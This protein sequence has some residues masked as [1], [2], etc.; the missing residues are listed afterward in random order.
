MGS[1]LELSIPFQL[2]VTLNAYQQTD[3]ILDNTTFPE[4]NLQGKWELL[5]GSEFSFSSSLLLQVTDDMLWWPWQMGF[6]TLYTLNASF[7]VTSLGDS[8]FVSDMTSATFGLRQ[9]G[10]RLTEEVLSSIVPVTRNRQLKC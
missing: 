2:N 5:N 3:I 6:Q 1:I 8:S 7:V 9:T 4:F 10:S